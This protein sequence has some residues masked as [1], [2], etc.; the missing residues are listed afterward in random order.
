[1]WFNDTYI[2]YVGLALLKLYQQYYIL[3]CASYDALQTPKKKLKHLNHDIYF[4]L[5]FC[6]TTK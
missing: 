2:F 3:P 1:M 5:A 6:H 4:A